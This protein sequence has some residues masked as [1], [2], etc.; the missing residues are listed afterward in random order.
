[1]DKALGHSRSM[2]REKGK[3]RA[4]RMDR[5]QELGREHEYTAKKVSGS[6]RANYPGDEF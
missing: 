2:K 3:G 6:R 4:V 5:E 1:M